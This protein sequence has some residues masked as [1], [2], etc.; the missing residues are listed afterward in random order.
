MHRALFVIFA[1]HPSSLNMFITFEN[2]QDL[3]FSYVQ[4][5]QE[6]K[7][8]CNQIKVEDVFYMLTL[9]WFSL[10]LVSV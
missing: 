1:F 6:F 10:G 9:P 7:S 5:L 2:F 4:V 3:V 8:L